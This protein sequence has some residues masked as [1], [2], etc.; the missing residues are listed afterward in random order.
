VAI[1]READRCLM[2]AV[3]KRHKVCEQTIYATPP[4]SAGAPRTAAPWTGRDVGG[5]YMWVRMGMR[6]GGSWRSGNTA[7]PLPTR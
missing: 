2:A 7:T 4:W 3:A 6:P 1:L 5:P